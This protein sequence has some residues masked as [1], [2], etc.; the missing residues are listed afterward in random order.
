MLHRFR[1]KLEGRGRFGFRRLVFFLFLFATGI[2][3]LRAL[4]IVAVNSHRLQTKLPGLD[5]RLGNILD[6]G[7]FRHVDRLADRAR[8]EGLGGGHH[9]DVT[10]PGNRASTAGGRQRAIKHREMCGIKVRRA[11][12]FAVLVDVR[13][14]VA[15]LLRRVAQLHQR[16]RHGVVHD[17]DYAATDQLLVLYACQVRLDAGGVAIHH[18]ADG[19]GGSQHGDLRILVAKLF[20]QGQ[21][22]VP[23][24]LRGQKKLRLHVFGLDAAHRVAMHANDV[25]H[26]LAVHRVAGERTHIFRNARGLRIS[27]AAHQRGDGAGHIATLVGIVGQGHGHEQ[28]AQIGVA[29]TQ[30]AKF[31]RILRDFFGRIAGEVHQNFLR[32]DGHVHGTRE[33]RHIEIAA[34]IDVFH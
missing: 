27:F 7:I 2:E 28:R 16:L 11:L 12:H 15:G 32:R 24:R 18:E 6:G 9:L 17:F 26:G 20:A 3:R 5:V 23:R 21:R 8:E 14:D 29:E 30:R 1:R 33:R 19:A 22:I 34:A 13:N 25:Q 31:V 4:G 10:S